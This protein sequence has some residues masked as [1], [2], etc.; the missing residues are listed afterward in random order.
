M[1]FVHLHLHSEYS[2]LD[3]AIRLADLPKRLT[4]LGQT[5]CAMTDHG[6]LYGA[7]D[8]YRSLTK[9]GLK[10]IMGLEIAIA[11]GSRLEHNNEGQNSRIVLLAENQDG[12]QNLIYLDSMAFI[13]GFWQEPRI[14]L[15]LLAERSAGLICLSGGLSGP[16]GLA[17]RDGSYAGLKET[18]EKYL[19]IFG[20]EH[21]FLEVQPNGLEDQEK[22]NRALYRLS[23]E[24]AI[25][26]VATNDCHYLLPEDYE[27]Q[28]VLTC[29]QNNCKISDPK[30]EWQRSRSFYLK[31]E[32]EMREYFSEHPEACDNTVRIAE[33]CNF[34]MRFGELFLPAFACPEG[35]EAPEYLAELS[36]AGLQRRLGKDEIPEAY[37]KRLNKELEIIVRMGYADYYLIVWDIV[38][39]AKEEGIAVGPGRGSGGASL[40]A[41]ALGITN[42]DSLKYDLVFERFL[43]PARVSMP[44]FDLDFCYERRGE[45]LDYVA[46]KYGTEHVCQVITFGTLAARACI[47]D[48]ARVLELPYSEGD[49]IAKMIPTSLNITLAGALEQNK[50][51]REE[52]KNNPQAAQLFKLAERI[53]GMPR[54]ASTHAAGVVISA[55]D[56][57][58]IAPI[59]RNDETLVVQ[60]D[61]DT[62]EDVGLLKFDFLGLRTMTVLREAREQIYK[63]HGVDVDY[64][65]MDFADPEVYRMLSEGRTGSVFQLESAG[66]TAFIKEV[67]PSNLEDIIAIISLYRPGPMEQIPRY[68]EAGRRPETISYDHPLLEEILKTT[69]GCIIYQEQVMR[70]VR[71][72][73]GF[74]MAQSDNVRRAM[75][76]KKPELMAR[77]EELFVNGGIDLDGGE[78]EGAVNRGVPEATARKIYHELM[79]FAGYAFN[80]AHATGYAVLAYQTAWLKCHYPAEFMAA[81]LNAYSGNH[82]KV[83]AMIR[84]AQA[85]GVKILPPTIN[86]GEYR[87]ITDGQ[88]IRYALGAVKNVGYNAIQAI[89]QEREANGKYQDFADFIE[90]VEPLDV[91]RKAIESLIQ[92]SSFDEFGQGRNQLL[93]V[94]EGA[95]AQAK[96]RRNSAI[97]GQVSL[98]DLAAQPELN[99]LTINYPQLPPLNSEELLR[100]E[101][102]MMGIFLSGHPLQDHLELIEQVVTMNSAD[103]EGLQEARANGAGVFESN[104]RLAGLIV[105]ARTLVTKKNEIMAF[106]QM[107]DMA[108]GYE[109]IVFPAIY[110]ECRQHILAGE[111]IYIEGRTSFRDEEAVK[112]IA[113]QILSLKE[114]K[115]QLEAGQIAPVG[116][117]QN[118]SEVREEQ[119]QQSAYRNGIRDSLPEPRLAPSEPRSMNRPVVTAGKGQLKLIVRVSEEDLSSALAFAE[120]FAGDLNCFIY[121]EA[122]NKFIQAEGGFDIQYLAELVRRYGR[123]NVLLC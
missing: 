101:R 53:E 93:A 55:K 49:R 67:G 111:L 4:E 70:I 77:Y 2:L 104:Q 89:V 64:E 52:L 44:D 80:K 100:Q 86:E 5:A 14:D 117:E 26:L 1:A 33:R 18:A 10:P 107:E 40:V 84:E 48:V 61:K 122:S 88:D 87:F 68:V 103:L 11:P 92:A 66:M 7:V 12:W 43:N 58:E 109:L 120:F 116:S 112:I 42:I 36:F 46:G 60:F 47:R 108:G 73:A 24:L 106:V 21:F 32:E 51:L 37:R 30:S 83:A 121:L 8:F 114:A 72:L 15:E 56:I 74:S 54:H 99:K 82:N 28:E 91:N 59:A 90:R 69:K 34:E 113:N 6:V 75:S 98:F 27:V 23:S 95:L 31:S 35:L 45:L 13:D 76:K 39:H 17:Y 94:F 97:D 19:E 81:M 115:A 57:R 16:L 3:G 50:E 71:D 65:G 123:E 105:D 62:I 102:E 79:A 20:P 63:N 25:D 29:L 118:S 22:L 85:S 9:H 110:S 96:E 78:I 38:R 41:Y 119:A